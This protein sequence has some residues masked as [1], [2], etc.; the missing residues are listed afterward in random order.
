MTTLP[1]KAKYPI[2]FTQSGVRFTLSLH[3]NWNSSFLF[4][5]STKIYRFKAKDSEIKY[6]K[7]CLGNISKHHTIN[8]KKKTR[9]KEIVNLIIF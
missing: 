2:N 5:N 6:Y 4:V 3:Y 7:L 1:S 9:F 8:N